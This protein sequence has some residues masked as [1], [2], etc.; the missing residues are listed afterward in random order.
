M[1]GILVIN[2]PKDWTSFD[3][4]A[5]IRGKFQTKK[6]GHTGTLD[7]QATGVLV[8]CLGKAT[9]LVEFLTKENK[10]YEAEITLGA[11]STDRKSVV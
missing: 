11:T 2:K 5:K 7:P 10:E 6:V 9:K 8:L 4:V 1:D 3:V